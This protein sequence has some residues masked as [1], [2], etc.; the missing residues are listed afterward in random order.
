MANFGI[1]VLMKVFSMWAPGMVVHP[2]CW[3][4]AVSSL[5]MSADVRFSVENGRV[6][7]EQRASSK[8]QTERVVLEWRVTGL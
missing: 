4:L 2:K 5:T 6:C 1:V 8:S 3:V 7:V